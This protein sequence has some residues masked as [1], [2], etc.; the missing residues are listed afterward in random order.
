MTKT[1][2]VTVIDDDVKLKTAWQGQ[3][4]HCCM[5]VMLTV[6]SMHAVFFFF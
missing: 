1:M 5:M 4:Y 6:A 2:M 3:W